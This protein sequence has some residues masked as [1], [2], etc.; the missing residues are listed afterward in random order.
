MND[1]KEK[2]E[3]DLII[4]K[5]RDTIVNATLKDNK[6]FEKKEQLHDLA[7]G[8]LKLSNIGLFKEI[9]VSNDI[10]NFKSL[11]KTKIDEDIL[12]ILESEDALEPEEPAESLLK[13]HFGD[14]TADEKTINAVKSLYIRVIATKWFEWIKESVDNEPKQ[15]SVG[16]STR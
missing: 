9:A 3:E 4:I 11:D 10:L 14:S 15:S 16:S 12:E 7:K 1:N 5:S 8:L 6:G 13:K 2:V